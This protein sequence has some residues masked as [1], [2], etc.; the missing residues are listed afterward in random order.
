MQFFSLDTE[1]IKQEIVKM[2]KIMQFVYVLKDL[3]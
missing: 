2:K 1:E 3:A